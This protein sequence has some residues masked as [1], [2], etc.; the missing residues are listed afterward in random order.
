MALMRDVKDAIA[1]A[2]SEAEKQS[3]LQAI[4]TKQNEYKMKNL[5]YLEKRRALN[6]ALDEKFKPQYVAATQRIQS[7]ENI[8]AMKL[9]ILRSKY[10][11]A[12]RGVL[13]LRNNLH[14]FS[15]KVYEPMILEVSIFFIKYYY[16]VWY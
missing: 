16:Y 14:L 1:L 11:H 2:G 5:E 9:E 10:D 13:W 15:G 6:K 3:Q 8:A 12:F 7:M 4:E